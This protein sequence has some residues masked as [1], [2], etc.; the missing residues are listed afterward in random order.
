MLTTIVLLG[1][2]AELGS[3]IVTRLFPKALIPTS[4]T[5]QCYSCSF[6]N[7]P[8]N[9]KTAPILE[10]RDDEGYRCTVSKHKRVMV[11]RVLFTIVL[12]CRKKHTL[13]GIMRGTTKACNAS[14]TELWCCQVDLCNVG[15]TCSSMK[16]WY[17]VVAVVIALDYF[18][19]IK[20]ISNIGGSP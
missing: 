11:C 18:S 3:S 9:T 10:F 5:L 2:F 4:G 8:L 6:C 20:T 1:R 17:S 13:N 7:D 12:R 14:N 16:C 15:V 19:P